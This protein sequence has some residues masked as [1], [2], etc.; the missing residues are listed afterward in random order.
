MTSLLLKSICNMRFHR[1]KIGVPCLMHIHEN[2]ILPVKLSTLR[3]ECNE[4]KYCGCRRW[5]CVCYICIFSLKGVLGIASPVLRDKFRAATGETPEVELPEKTFE[6]VR[7]F[8]ECIYPDFYRD[9]T[10]EY[11]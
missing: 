9:I 4:R 2:E 11:V 3:I 6:D 8:L 10:C 7:L 1:K 5:H